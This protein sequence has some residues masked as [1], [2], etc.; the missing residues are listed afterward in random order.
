[1]GK[2]NFDR[3][4]ANQLIGATMAEVSPFNKV[5]YVDGTNGSN[6]NNGQDPDRAFATV[7]QAI[8]LGSAGDH[9]VVAPGTYTITAALVPKA[10][11][12]IRAA[13]VVPTAPTVII[14]GN[15]ADLVQ[16]D[17]NGVTFLGLEVKASGSTADNLVDIADTADVNGVTFE[18][19][20]FNGADQTSVVG[21]QADDA[22]FAVTGMVITN[23]LFRDLTGTM[24]DIGALGMAYSRIQYNVF[25]HDIN[26]GIGIALADT[27]AFATGK[28]WVIADNLFLPFDATGNEVGIS[29]AGTE[30]AT[31]A[32]I[33][34]R[35]MFSYGVAG[36][37]V[38]IDKLGKATI[39][40]YTAAAT[41]GGTV[42][43]TGS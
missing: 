24:V 18:S 35:N 26:S 2:T 3:V 7:A 29:I 39:N 30:D 38:T 33:I 41:G 25:A 16:V 36:T 37:S 31:G 9:I 8:S 27:T 23:C 15:I 42:I 32:G 34:T 40:N 20:V 28:A 21:I 1:M 4:V 12:T 14:T 11:M 22:T 10:R 43:T 17:V 13:V 19:C 5:L 6:T